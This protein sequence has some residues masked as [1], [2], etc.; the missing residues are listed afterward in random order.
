M[1][2][3]AAATAL[4][5]DHRSRPVPPQR[6]YAGRTGR[7]GRRRGDRSGHHPAR[8]DLCSGGPTNGA[9]TGI[10]IGGGGLP[11]GGVDHAGAGSATQHRCGRSRRALRRDPHQPCPGFRR[12]APS[13]GAGTERVEQLMTFC[14]K[15]K[16]QREAEASLTGQRPFEQLSAAESRC[17]EAAPIGSQ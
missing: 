1:G 3:A 16:R 9:L 7:R 4:W 8:S 15:L 11:C 6:R 5:F 10:C 14:R 12:S 13:H 2:G 17:P